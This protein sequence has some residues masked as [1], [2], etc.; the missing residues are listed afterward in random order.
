MKTNIKN[1]RVVYFYFLFVL[2]MVAIYQRFHLK[3]QSVCGVF[4]IFTPYQRVEQVNRGEQ[5]IEE[6]QGHFGFQRKAQ[7][8]DWGKCTIFPY[9]KSIKQNC[10]EKV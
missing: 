9:I 5:I 4:D 3:I 1:L 10:G 7:K 8:T 6:R 2:R